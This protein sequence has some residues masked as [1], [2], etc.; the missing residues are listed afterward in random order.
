MFSLLLVVS[1]VGVVIMM[2]RIG[3]IFPDEARTDEEQCKASAI[4]GNDTYRISLT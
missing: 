1:A 2:Q 3:L 4:Q